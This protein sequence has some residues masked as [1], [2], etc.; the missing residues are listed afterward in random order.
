ML[1][2]VAVMG[3]ST[4]F[5][6]AKA[7][8]CSGIRNPILPVPAVRFTGSPSFASKTMVILPGQ[9]CSIKRIAEEGAFLIYQHKKRF[10]MGAPFYSKDSIHGLGI[11]GICS[12][13]IKI[14]G[15]ECNDTAL[16]YYAGSLIDYAFLRF[17]MI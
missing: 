13:S 8:G 5:T 4:A 6:S 7:T 9:K 2:L 12:E 10:V 3:T 16:L 17:F 14:S 11:K 1:A 15:R